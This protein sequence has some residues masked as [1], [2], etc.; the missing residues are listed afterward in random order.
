MGAVQITPLVLHLRRHKDNPSKK[1]LF[2]E[3]NNVFQ[4]SRL[5]LMCLVVVSSG[6]DVSIL[7]MQQQDLYIV[8]DVLNRKLSFASTHCDHV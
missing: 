8:F 6:F 5:E 4:E 7:G 2:Q 3:P 1:E